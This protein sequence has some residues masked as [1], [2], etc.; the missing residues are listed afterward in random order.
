MYYQTIDQINDGNALIFRLKKGKNN[1]NEFVTFNDPKSAC[2]LIDR[3]ILTNHEIHEVVLTRQDPSV[4][5]FFDIEYYTD[6]PNSEHFTLIFN[7]IYQCGKIFGTGELHPFSY[8]RKDI[9]I[10]SAVRQVCKKSGEVLFKNSYHV[11]VNTYPMKNIWQVKMFA[12]FVCHNLSSDISPFIDMAI[13]RNNANFRVA[14]TAKDDDTDTTLIKQS[15][16]ETREWL[17]TWDDTKKPV[18]LTEYIQKSFLCLFNSP[19]IET[20]NHESLLQFNTDYIFNEILSFLGSEGSTSALHAELS[21]LKPRADESADQ[22]IPL[23]RKDVTG[24]F[25]CFICSRNHESD[26]AYLILSFMSHTWWACFLNCYRV[27]TK[28]QSLFICHFKLN[29]DGGFI[30]CTITVDRF[31]KYNKVIEINSQS[32]KKTEKLKKHDLRLICNDFPDLNIEHHNVDDISEIIDCSLDNSINTISYVLSEPGTGKTEFVYKLAQLH[33]DKSFLILLPLRTLAISVSDRLKGFGFLTHVGSGKERLSQFEVGSKVVC[34]INSLPK[35]KRNQ[36]DIVIMDEM[37]AILNQFKTLGHSIH[38][39]LALIK[40][41]V[42][43]AKWVYCMDAHLT[44][45]LLF[46]FIGHWFDLGKSQ[47][48]LVNDFCR[49]INQNWIMYTKDTEFYEEMQRAVFNNESIFI[50]CT[51]KLLVKGIAELLSEVKQSNKRIIKIVGDTPLVEKKDL[52]ENFCLYIREGA[53]FVVSPA[54]TVGIST[55]E[56]ISAVFCVHTNAFIPSLTSFQQCKR[57]RL[58]KTFHCLIGKVPPRTCP[59][60]K[61]GCFAE[62]RQNVQFKSST[63]L[64]KIPVNI[65]LKTKELIYMKCPA[66][67][68]LIAHALILNESAIDPTLKFIEIILTTG[69]TITLAQPTTDF[70]FTKTTTNSLINQ[71]KSAQLAELWSDSRVVVDKKQTFEELY[72]EKLNNEHLLGETTKVNKNCLTFVKIAEIY[73]VKPELITDKFLKQYTPHNVISKFKNLKLIARHESLSDL[74]TNTIKKEQGEL[75]NNDFVEFMHNI[76]KK[77]D[78]LSHYFTIFDLLKMC[79]VANPFNCNGFIV[80]SLDELE[81]PYDKLE[82][83]RKVNQLFGHV[84]KTSKNN[85]INKKSHMIKIINKAFETFGFKLK[86]ETASS[87]NLIFNL[88]KLFTYH[89]M[90]NEP[91]KYDNTNDK[92]VVNYHQGLTIT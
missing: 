51:S 23:K 48:L 66:L 10:A 79:G 67:D 58:C 69:A 57:P 36:F 63:E 1:N 29:H 52:I 21:K 80:N 43:H 39:T 9:L 11:I 33:Q 68:F 61:E 3:F 49:G 30:E 71:S 28:G 25:Y 40:F 87:S 34:I 31:D 62:L 90:A 70:K 17:I 72:F 35:I 92:P 88:C 20:N 44:Y 59:Q 54:V 45:S 81:K 77:K 7:Q 50:V 37:I 19:V 12:Q 2:A 65:D 42:K 74:I 53:I 46:P 47:S 22:F 76:H 78:T 13:Y 14:G 75:L 41:Y 15:N 24:P 55:M 85:L 86:R 27:T 91:L 82:I 32:D 83:E 26:N 56:F 84:K 73:G 4:K 16:A 8:T 6:I 38:R 18:D 60:T 5:L 64:E 89:N